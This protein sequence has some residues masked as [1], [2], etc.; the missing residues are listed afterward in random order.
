MLEEVSLTDRHEKTPGQRCILMRWGIVVTPL[1]MP[2][3]NFYAEE[4]YMNSCYFLE[5]TLWQ[6]SCTVCTA[7]ILT[8]VPLPSKKRQGQKVCRLGEAIETGLR[9][10]AVVGG[11]AM[12]RIVWLPAR[13][14]RSRKCKTVTLGV[15]GGFA[16]SVTR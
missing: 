1:S 3:V 9:P 11:R 10:S 4:I 5:H 14:S 12:V 2:F 6:L 13:E 7:E 16:T 15:S 8:I